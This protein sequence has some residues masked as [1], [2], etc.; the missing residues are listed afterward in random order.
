MPPA[1]VLLG[2][3]HRW[4][5]ADQPGELDVFAD[6]LPS[7]EAAAGRAHGLEGTV[8]D[9]RKVVAL[10]ADCNPNLLELLFCREEE[11][12]LCTPLGRR[13]RAAASAFLSQ[14]VRQ[15]Y[16]GYAR[17]QL[18][19]IRT[20]RHWL[21]EPPAAPPTRAAFGL[22]EHGLLP[23]EQ[24]ALGGQERRF[25]AAQKGWEQYQ[26][27]LRSRNPAR[28]ALEAAHGYDTKHGAHL[29]R[30]LRMAGE[31]LETGRVHVWRGDRDGPELQAI[32]A[33]A[34]PYEA[35]IAWAEAADA[36]LDALLASGR[37]AVPAQPDLDALEALTVSLMQEGLR[38]PGGSR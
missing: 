16:G 30:L 5:Q 7:E 1:A 9:L 2:F 18:A 27:W 13:L 3:R 23:A 21:L 33:G 12:R 19:R 28:A 15:S 24:L 26:G 25:R 14:R 38:E 22:P 4:E 10:A 34:W 31:I 20:H 35:L 8:Y 32:R 36:A 17:G 6:L 37:A 29:V 11:V